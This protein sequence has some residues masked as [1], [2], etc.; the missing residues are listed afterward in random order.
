MS[1]LPQDVASHWTWPA[2]TQFAAC[3]D[4]LINDT[5]L[6]RCDGDLVGVVQRLNTRI[7]VPEVHEDLH[8]A[9]E[10]VAARGLLT[11]RLVP[12][13]AGTLWATVDGEVWRRLTP[14]GERTLHR[15]ASAEQARSAGALV[16]RFHRALDD[17][18]WRFR[19]VRPGAHDTLGHLARLREAVAAHRDHRLYDQV[20]P[21]A[22]AIAGHWEGWEGS[23]EQPERVI[24]GD[25][26]VSN[27]RWTKGEA[28]AVIDL[29]T[30]Q[31]GSLAVEL[32]DAMRSWCNPGGEDLASAS[33][34]VGLFGAAMAGYR[35]T[36]QPSDEDL[37][38]VV[39]GVDRIAT[40]LA[41]RFAADAL[42]ESYF[43]FDPKHG[44]R[45]EHNLLRAKGQ[46]SLA[47][48]VRKRR[49]AAEQALSG[50]L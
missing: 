31:M 15:L 44:G 18:S 5:F 45:G 21:L 2:G 39:S 13:L 16:G 42:N 1:T 7:F 47:R 19:S 29:D 3:A 28:V 27:L 17:F 41:A 24:H 12:T 46:L 23:L 43:G 35:Q 8:A 38:A 50:A 30:L 11:P 33:F 40:E 48:S 22:D 10:H 36:A 32:G 4:G 6:A 34:D 9:T 37:L 25:L 49:G 26:K 20:A 14:V